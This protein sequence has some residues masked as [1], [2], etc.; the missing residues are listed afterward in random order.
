LSRVPAP[1]FPGVGEVRGRHS[2]GLTLASNE[3]LAAFLH[4]QVVLLGKLLRIIGHALFPE[5]VHDLDDLALGVEPGPA[6]HSAALEAGL[7]VAL[8]RIVAGGLFTGR[9]PG[10]V[11]HVLELMVAGPVDAFITQWFSIATTT[12]HP[13]RA[14]TPEFG[15]GREAVRIFNEGTKTLAPLRRFPRSS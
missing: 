9:S 3:P 2:T 1:L 12:R 4:G 5:R 15:L 13:Q 11:A 6:H 14:V 7:V 8:D 10:R